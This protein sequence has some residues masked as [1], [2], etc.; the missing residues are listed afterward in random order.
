MRASDEFFYKSNLDAYIEDVNKCPTSSHEQNI[1]LAKKMRQGDN[2]AK[3]KLIISNLRLALKIAFRYKSFTEN[4][5]KLDIN[6]LIQAAN[7]GL[8]LGIDK[9]DPDLGY[10]LSTYV[11]FYISR[12]IKS[13]IHKNIG[14]V[15]EQRHF[16]DLVEK[17]DKFCNLFLLEN[18]REPSYEE[19]ANA[20]DTTPEQVEKEFSYRRIYIS[21][22]EHTYLKGL[23]G[24]NISV[25]DNVA[26]DDNI[27]DFIMSEMAFEELMDYIK[28]T[29]NE[30]AQFILFSRLEIGQKFLE[31]KK[32]ADIY[33]VKH[34]SIQQLHDRSLKKLRKGLRGRYER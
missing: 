32:I 16:Q 26:D 30:K 5:T 4:N 10:K 3:E 18:E 20:F 31:F 24:Y 33:G 27:E 2:E 6:D 11:V 28:N 1:I 13:T 17:Y 8:M 29:L 22:D 23:T 21:L 19:I 34:Q 15:V 14:P 25:V 12:E 7:I 9:F